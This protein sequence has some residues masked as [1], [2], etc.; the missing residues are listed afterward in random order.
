MQS[1]TFHLEVGMCGQSIDQ[2]DGLREVTGTWLVPNF[3][4]FKIQQH[5]SPTIGA[6]GLISVGIM[7]S[8]PSRTWTVRDGSLPRRASL[9][10]ES[11]FRSDVCI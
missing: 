4:R 7:R 8:G 11:H 9:N 1:A 2:K 6:E 3:A 5:L 10:V